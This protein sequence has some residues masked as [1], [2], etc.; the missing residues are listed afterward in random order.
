MTIKTIKSPFSAMSIRSLINIF[1]IAQQLNIC[2]LTQMNVVHTYSRAA[3][4]L[5]KRKFT[6]IAALLFHTTFSESKSL[7][8]P[9]LLPGQKD[10]MNSMLW[11]QIQYF[12][13]MERETK[14]AANRRCPALASNLQHT[15]NPLLPRVQKI[16]I[17]KLALTDF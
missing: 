17:R 10:Y 5:L 8:L 1:T 16:K 2:P 13:N 3:A 4:R 7:N 9:A 14:M 11:G 15:F 6:V 12:K